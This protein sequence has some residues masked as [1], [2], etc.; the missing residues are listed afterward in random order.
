MVRRALPGGLNHGT[1]DIRD[2]AWAGKADRKKGRKEGRS[3]RDKLYSLIKL[4]VDRG[5]TPLAG[6]SMLAVSFSLS[7]RNLVHL[8]KYVFLFFSRLAHPWAW[9]ILYSVFK[10]YVRELYSVC[11]F[12]VFSFKI[13]KWKRCG[14]DHF[15]NFTDIKIN[16]L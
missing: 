3:P 2:A 9:H 15:E 4:A 10:N 12:T 6:C 7:S 8:W 5:N 1:C 11:S 16:K 14:N 13:E